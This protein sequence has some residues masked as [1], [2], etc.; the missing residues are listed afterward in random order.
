MHA[1]QP[2]DR[3]AGGAGVGLYLMV[4]AASAVLFHVVPGV[5]TEVVCAFDV[6]ASGLQL[7]QLGFVT[8]LHDTTGALVP[9]RRQPVGTS[10]R[11]ER[12]PRRNRLVAIAAATVAVALALGMWRALHAPH[13]KAQSTPALA[14]PVATLVLDSQ[15]S[16]AEVTIDGIVVGDT[17]LT[18]TTRESGKDIA[19]VLRAA[20]YRDAAVHAKLPAIGETRRVLQP[21]E[22]SAE[23]VRVHFVSRPP[24]A[25][26]V[27]LGAAWPGELGN[28][29]TPADVFV[30]AGEVQRFELTMPHH[31]PFVVAPF[32]PT[33]GTDAIEQGGAL[34]DA[35]SP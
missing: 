25:R 1:A 7:A 17:P 29:Y 19:V 31:A 6:G 20:G 18:W 5:A 14:L 32:T 9:A 27:S 21:L 3:K 22:R 35:S 26:V 10:P 28:T 11:F 2:I 4:S 16:G 23:L 8:E 30:H 13:H 15:P 33:R 12:P 24:G 34:A